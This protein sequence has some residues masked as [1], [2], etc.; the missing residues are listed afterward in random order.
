MSLVVGYKTMATDLIKLI[1]DLVN[2][3][4]SVIIRYF[5]IN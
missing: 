1:L 5:L 4:I 3:N 2:E